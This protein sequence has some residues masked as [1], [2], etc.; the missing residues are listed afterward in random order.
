MINGKA[1]DFVDRI[2]S[3]QDTVFIYNGIKYWFQGY[4]PCANTVH[5]EVFQISPESDNYIW[6]YNGNSVSEGQDAFQNAPI[7]NGKT[8]WEAEKDIVWTDD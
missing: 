4:M 1:E 8:F 3:C 5:M 7:F 2:Y 6:E